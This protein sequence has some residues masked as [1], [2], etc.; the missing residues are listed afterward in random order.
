ME[1]AVLSSQ[2]EQF[3]Y[4]CQRG[5]VLF[6]FDSETPL[7]RLF[8]TRRYHSTQVQERTVGGR[9]G[10]RERRGC[11]LTWPKQD[12]RVQL[13]GSGIPQNHGV[14]SIWELQWKGKHNERA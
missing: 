14:D 11:M 1:G 7:P 12:E 5:T 9:G 4:P 6:A 8:Q 3:S 13:G 10:K 2:A